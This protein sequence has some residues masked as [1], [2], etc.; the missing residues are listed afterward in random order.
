MTSHTINSPTA[1]HTA[2]SARQ[3][4]KGDVLRS[5]SGIP[6][7]RFDNPLRPVTEEAEQ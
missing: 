2:G 7:R 4:G 6:N 3:Q 5:R 1:P